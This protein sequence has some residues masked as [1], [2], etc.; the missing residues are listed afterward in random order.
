MRKKKKK[1]KERK[2][3]KSNFSGGLFL[4]SRVPK[5][6]FTSIFV[7]HSLCMLDLVF[8]SLAII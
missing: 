5:G 4:S 8:A 1:E 6:M 3:T 7:N 2:M